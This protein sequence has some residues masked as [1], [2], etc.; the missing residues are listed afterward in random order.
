MVVLNSEEGFLKSSLPFAK[1]T[2]PLEFNI[3]YLIET[4]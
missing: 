1:Q 4:P 3:Y 2:T